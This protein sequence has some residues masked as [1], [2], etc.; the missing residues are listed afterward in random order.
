MEKT[1][2]TLYLFCP[3]YKKV[4]NKIICYNVFQDISTKLYY[5][6]SRDCIFTGYDFNFSKQ[7]IDLFIEIEPKDRENGYKNIEEAIKMYEDSFNG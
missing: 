4:D 7:L 1:E 5:I 3:V 2:S 6:Q